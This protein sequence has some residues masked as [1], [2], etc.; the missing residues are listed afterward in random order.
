MTLQCN[1]SWLEVVQRMGEVGE[2]CIANSLRF[3]LE[4]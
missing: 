3:V 2:D 4:M 1:L